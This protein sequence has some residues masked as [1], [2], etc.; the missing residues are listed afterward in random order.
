MKTPNFELSVAL[1]NKFKKNLSD[2]VNE[3]KISEEQKK[4]RQ[5]ASERILEAKQNS[6][7]KLNLNG[8][9]LS[10]LPDAIFDLKD[11]E[12]LNL[13]NNRLESISPKI[14]NL[15]KLKYLNL[16]GSPK[17]LYISKEIVSLP[18]L[19]NVSLD[20]PNLTEENLQKNHQRLTKENL[21]KNHQPNSETIVRE[22]EH[23]K[24]LKTQEKEKK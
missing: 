23:L 13:K 3:N 10:S 2:W 24:L 7:T 5:T 15:T 21:Q 20:N 11:L 9:E 17:S 12:D 1:R 14:T 22:I 18:N 16:E 6:L 19:C 4:S 8:L